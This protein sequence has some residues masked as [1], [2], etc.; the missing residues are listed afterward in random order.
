MLIGGKYL[1]DGS[2]ADEIARRG[3]SVAGHDHPVAMANRH[4]GGGVRRQ[5]GVDARSPTERLGRAKAQVVQKSQ[6]TRPRIVLGAEERQVHEP[7]SP[8]FWM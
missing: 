3:P 6:E 1:F 2:V 7:Y 8:P 4:N 5:T